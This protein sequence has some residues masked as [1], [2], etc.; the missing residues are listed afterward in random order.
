M[1]SCIFKKV[2]EMS[3]AVII[4]ECKKD[5]GGVKE[6][7]SLSPNEK[8]DGAMGLFSRLL[9]LDTLKRSSVATKPEPQITYYG[10]YIPCEIK[11][12]PDE[13]AIHVYENKSEALELV[14]RYKL[15]RFKAF[16]NRQDAIS[17]ALR[18]AEHHDTT[19]GNDS[20]KCIKLGTHL[21]HVRNVCN[22][23]RSIAYDKYISKHKV[24]IS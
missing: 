21:T 12:G 19:D 1:I 17:F 7:L 9:R 14:K 5:V 6:G 22:A 15:A 16:H 4:P 18:G 13:E 8:R 11:K 2:V 23:I 10:V 20:C 3:K 24:Q